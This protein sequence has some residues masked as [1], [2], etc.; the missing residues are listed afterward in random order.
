MIDFRNP[1]RICFAG[2]HSHP[3]SEE[4]RPP[5]VVVGSPTT[6]SA[7]L[8]LSK[9]CPAGQTPCM[10][11]NC[12]LFQKAI[13]GKTIASSTLFG[14]SPDFKKACAWA[15]VQYHH[16]TRVY[17]A[18]DHP[19]S[20]PVKLLGCRHIP[21]NRPMW[22]NLWSNCGKCHAPCWR[23]CA[24]VDDGGR[25]LATERPAR[26][27]SPSVPSSQTTARCVP[28]TKI[29]ELSLSWERSSTKNPSPKGYFWAS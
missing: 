15:P 22:K 24:S 1:K 18:L 12:A 5:G 11:L 3:P 21:H 25:E 14:Q 26:S 19:H 27:W 13:L 17:W 4:K 16:P 20:R 10:C 29:V 9:M 8:L 6:G 7:P 23:S 28:E 2:S